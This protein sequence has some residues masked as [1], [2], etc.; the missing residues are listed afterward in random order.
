MS[1]SKIFQPKTLVVSLLILV[2]AVLAFGYAAANIV[3]DSGAGIGESVVSGYTIA[4]IDYTLVASNPTTVYSVAFTVTPTSGA[5]AA[6]DVRISIDGTNY[7]DICTNVSTLWTCTF[8]S[9]ITVLS[10]DS[11]DVVA[12]SN[13]STDYVP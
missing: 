7:L 13:E 3:P 5:P 8:A 11:L 6:A 9:P 10:I 12:L 2:L 4:A 1:L